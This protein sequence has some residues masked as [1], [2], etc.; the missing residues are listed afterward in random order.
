MARFV[1]EK[2]DCVYVF[3][4]DDDVSEFT[5][6]LVSFV[7]LMLRK[8]I[9]VNYQIIPGRIDDLATEFMFEKRKLN[10]ELIRLNQHGYVHKQ[11]I[12]GIQRWSEYYGNL[13]FD[14]QYESIKLGRQIMKEKFG[15]Y[16]DSQVFT[17]PAHKYNKDTVRALELLGFSVL[18]AG[19]RTSWSGKLFDFLGSGFNKTTIL[20]RRVSYHG[21]RLP[22]SK[23][24][25]ISTSIDVDMSKSLTGRKI[26][27]SS[28]Q[29]LDDFKA[30]GKRSGHVG[31]LFHHQTLNFEK[32][33]TL[34]D[35]LDQ[36]RSMGSKIHL[37]HLEFIAANI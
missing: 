23:L 13:H 37:C 4:R 1:E 21:R 33:D 27:K 28:N 15:D 36:L 5:P 29:V 14:L 31:L 16:F 25:D 10:P 3:V 20:N 35:I 30:V 22:S 34:A 17:P 26:T 32:L 12:D 8:E 6:E 11:T 19:A 7:D 24:L 2:D 18:S 9:P